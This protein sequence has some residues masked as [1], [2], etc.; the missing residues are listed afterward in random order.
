V[1]TGDQLVITIYAKNE[2]TKPIAEAR[3]QVRSL[4]SEVE[5]SGVAATRSA[6]RFGVL[7]NSWNKMSGFIGGLSKQLTGLTSVFGAVGLALAIGLSVKQSNAFESAMLRIHTQA[8]ASAMEVA[9]LSGQVL[10]LAPNVG[11]GPVALADA[12]YHVESVGYRGADALKI[13]QISAQAAQIGNANL[14][15]TTYA[16]TSTM[17]SFELDGVGGATKAMGLLNA[18]VGQGDMRMQDL[19]GAI[20]T[21]IFSTAQTF[22]LS[23]QSTGAALDFLTDRGEKANTASTR[24]A[25]GITLMAAPSM[26]SAQMLGAMGLASSD[27]TT[28]SAA[29]S[30]ALQKAGLS[31]STLASDMRKPDGIYVALKDLKD[32]MLASGMSADTSA[33]L[34]ARVFGGA[35]TGKA[36]MALI[37]NLDGV[38]AKYDAVGTQADRF[39]ADW[40]ATTHTMSYRWHAFTAAVQVDM[41]K[42]GDFLKPLLILILDGFG[43]A[44]NI[45]RPFASGIAAVWHG[46]SDIGGELRPL[47]GLL[48]LVFGAGLVLV[49]QG[50]GYALRDVLAPALHGVADV[51]GFLNR[52][53]F[54]VIGLASA[55]TVLLLPALISAISELV[56][57]GAVGIGVKFLEITAG[58]KAAAL[59]LK[60][61]VW[62]NPYLVAAAAIIAGI[63]AAVT[64]LGRDSRQ[65]K[66]DVDALTGSIKAQVDGLGNKQLQDTILGQISDWKPTSGSIDGLSY[67]EKYGVNTAALASTLSDPKTTGSFKTFFDGLS[68]GAQKAI[69]FGQKFGDNGKL[70]DSFKSSL[71]S[72][73][74]AVRQ[75]GELFSKLEKDGS[76]NASTITHLVA[77][78]AKLSTGI[79]ETRVKT[80]ALT[81]AQK[82]SVEKNLT[83]GMLRKQAEATQNL[84]TWQKVLAND[85]KALDANSKEY[86]KSV[87][88]IGNSIEQQFP[89]FEGY[90]AQLKL[91]AQTL[92]DNIGQEV[93]AIENQQ[94]NVQLLMTRGYSQETI[95]ALVAKGPE[96]VAA[97]ATAT[98]A[99]LGKLN[100]MVGKRMNDVRSLVTTEG[101]A[102]GNAAITAQVQGLYQ[103][104]GDLTRAQ[105]AAFVNSFQKVGPQL[106]GIA[107]TIGRDLPDKTAQGIL[108]NRTSLI[109]GLAAGMTVPQQNAMRTLLSLANEGGAKMA[110]GLASAIASGTPLVVSKQQ[111]L[112]AGINSETAKILK[113]VGITITTDDQASA[114]IAALQALLNTFQTTAVAGGWL[115]PRA[116][117]AAPGS[118]TVKVASAN[119]NLFERHDA[120]IAPGG[121]MRLWA[122]PETG[123]EAYIPL[124]ASKRQR[125]LDIWKETGK[126]LGVM[127]Y[128]DGGIAGRPSLALNAQIN[129]E[130]HISAL[131][132]AINSA[133]AAATASSVSSGNAGPGQ[134]YSKIIDFMKRS[135][136]G[137]TQADPGLGRSG[138]SWHEAGDAIDFSGGNMEAMASFWHG[139]A[140]FLLEEIHSPGYY[141]K[142]GRDVGPGFYGPEVVAQHFNHVHIAA[143]DSAMTTLLGQ[144]RT[145]DQGGYLHP[146]LNVVNNGLGRPEPVMPQQI[147]VGAIRKELAGSSSGGSEPPV[148]IGA[149]AIVI[150]NPSSDVDV[151]QAIA[152]GIRSYLRDRKE[153]S[154]D[155]RWY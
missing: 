13:L 17:K 12:L 84:V 119:G 111:M 92:L 30:E 8:G 146:G 29:M 33:A 44:G 126:H 83:P 63:A 27:V 142:N 51:I 95:G 35:R 18:I 71:T 60:E 9:N 42:I 147:M 34:I 125:S 16:L 137:F 97:A 105:Q 143:S 112:R 150:T 69:L 148:V 109:Q 140:P 52:N 138:H 57:L 123:G 113:T 151:E 24:L 81:D 36:I 89:I 120:Q 82:Q 23:L 25:M 94:K 90:R 129:L 149:G 72:T 2:L 43:E 50:V 77:G 28:A 58:I 153:R 100:Q 48:A 5:K 62:S 98:D 7:G 74:P 21:G 19:N 80:Q 64:I 32:R 106:V 10:K 85:Q 133:A 115:Q 102:T 88:N 4:N 79:D 101:L 130:S 96:Y 70:M 46:L 127:G 40:I 3:A 68:S 26:K 66:V 108:A 37:Q 154:G 144:T 53:R 87:Q 121:A 54:I 15:D 124:G 55:I 116:G 61:F 59:A 131:T 136:I 122:E 118:P 110:R 6:S 47:V 132:A 99:Q 14:D 155:P 75:F 91:N 22:G 135:G 31:T 114:K 134:S 107:Q 1:Q 103:K 65:T 78:F 86:A 145:M 128:A 45:L 11:T 152:A 76:V 41:V 141:V 38:K 56:A 67:L 39:G 104:A 139:Y 73:N 20:Q 117:V 93:T 49:V